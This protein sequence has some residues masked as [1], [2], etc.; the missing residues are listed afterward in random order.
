[1]AIFLDANGYEF[2]IDVDGS[3]RRF[4]IGT[5][6]REGRV[7]TSVHINEMASIEDRTTLDIH[8]PTALW[9]PAKEGGLE[10]VCRKAISLAIQEGWFRAKGHYSANHFDENID[11]WPGEMK[12]I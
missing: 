11:S 6:C 4:H 10:L 8:L 9:R 12:R 5:V 7:P 2:E 1:M 3:T